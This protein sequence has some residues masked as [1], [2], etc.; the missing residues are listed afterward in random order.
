M[1]SHRHSRCSLLDATR[2]PL[3]RIV[4]SVHAV[5]YSKDKHTYMYEWLWSPGHWNAKCDSIPEINL[6][7]ASTVLLLGNNIKNQLMLKFLGL[8]IIPRSPYSL[9][10]RLYLCPGSSEVLDTAVRTHPG[11]RS[12]WRLF[13]SLLWYV[14]THTYMNFRF[15]LLFSI[16]RWWEKWFPRFYSKVLCLYADACQHQFSSALWDCGQMG[17]SAE[18]T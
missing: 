3:W 9:Y 11:Y 8:A 14:I 2:K 5:L 13:S 15:R 1:I 7:F 16:F 4:W 10:Q 18:V 12:G 6:F 17:G